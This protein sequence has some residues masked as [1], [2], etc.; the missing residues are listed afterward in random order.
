MSENLK[1]SIAEE[2][3]ENL[4]YYKENAK[5][6]SET[7]KNCNIWHI[8][9]KSVSLWRKKGYYIL[10]RLKMELINSEK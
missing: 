1:K 5:I 7:L 8:G 10:P 2:I 6:I 3:S 9:G 4:T